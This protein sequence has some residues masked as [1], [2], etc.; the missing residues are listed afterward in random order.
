VNKH[1]FETIFGLQ[2]ASFGAVRNLWDKDAISSNG[3]KILTQ[4]HPTTQIHLHHALKLNFK[5]LATRM[6][7]WF[8]DVDQHLYSRLLEKRALIKV[9]LIFAW[10]F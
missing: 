3:P 9:N 2:V 5:I 6:E 7:I 8:A 10:Y 1:L 4:M